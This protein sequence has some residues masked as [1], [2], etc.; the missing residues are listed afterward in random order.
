MGSRSG[1]NRVMWSFFSQVSSSLGSILVSLIAARGLNQNDFG[2]FAMVF[3]LSTL[4]VGTV[5]AFTAEV[6][7]FDPPNSLILTRRTKIEGAMSTSFAAA[8]IILLLSAATLAVAGRSMDLV[9]LVAICIAIPII[10]D[11]GRYVLIGE[12]RGASAIFIELPALVVLSVALFASITAP[13]T[14]V[15]YGAWAISEVSAAAVTFW[16][17]RSYWRPTI[18]S[19]VTWWDFVKRLG[20]RYIADFWLTNGLTSGGVFVVSVIAGPVAAG[21]IRAAQVLLTPTLLLTRAMSLALAPEMTRASS[22]G[23]R[24]RVR[25]I[26]VSLAGGAVAMTI[27]TLLVAALLPAGL[28]VL[29]LGDNADT[30]LNTLPAAS[31]ALAAS[32]VAIAAGVGLRSQGAISYAVRSKVMTFPISAAGLIFGTLVGGAAGSQVGLAIGEAL[33]SV[34]NWHRFWRS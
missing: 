2:L 9:V 23:R 5:R 18:T 32:G 14:S 16:M 6:L 28:F 29:A 11:F 8:I 12:G 22:E 27:F 19:V 20:P 3:A 34:L 13:G 15:V 25:L 33:R 31:F 4:L 21:S 24:R 30:A 17:L 26:A 10:H 7:L 1:R